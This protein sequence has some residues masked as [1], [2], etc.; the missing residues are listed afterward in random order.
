MMAFITLSLKGY[1]NNFYTIGGYLVTGFA[2]GISASAYKAK[3]KAKDMPK[4][5]RRLHEKNY[6]F[7]HHLRS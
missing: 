7:I 1:Y 3:A 5:R 4:M 6:K 2:N